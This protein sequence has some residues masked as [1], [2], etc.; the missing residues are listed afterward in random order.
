MIRL[1]SVPGVSRFEVAIRNLKPQNAC[2]TGASRS[3]TEIEIP[4]SYI[5]QYN[6]SLE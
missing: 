3:H 6:S 5:K 2:Q 4:L 1:V